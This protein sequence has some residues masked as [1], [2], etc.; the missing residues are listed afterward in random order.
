M[1]IDL[2]SLMIMQSF[3][4]ACA[5]AVMLAAWSQN[6]KI[7]ALAL[8]GIADILAA[9]GFVSLMLGLSLRQPTWSILGVTLLNFQS[10]LTW[11]AARTVD[12]KPA[13]IVV[14]FVG[15]VA[16]SLA[17]VASGIDFANATALITGTIYILAAATTFWLGRKDHLAAR[18]PLAFLTT[19]HALALAIGIYSSLNGS[20]VQNGL[21][22][23]ASLFGVIYF[24]SIVFALGTSAFLLALIKERNEAAGMTAA[25]TD[26]LTGIASRAALLESGGR[27]LERCRRKG[28]PISVM[29]F[30]LDR[31]KAVNDRHGHAV[32]DA[33]I[34]KFCE[35]VTAA[36][37]PTDLFGRMGG[38]EFAVVLPESSMEAAWVRAERI[39]ASFAE[40][41]RFV[42]HHQVNATV[43]GGVSVSVRSEQTLEELLEYSDSALYSAKAH[44]RD[45]IKRAEQPKLES[46]ITN[47]LRIA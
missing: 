40:G 2:P 17:G 44:G 41:C 16:V 38:E 39:R 25:R 31:F 4:L 13:P 19:L 37:R 30:D 3:A 15:P 27:V 28:A 14:V 36:L 47:V 18:V 23:L 32:G 34:Q 22:S 9:G 42:R 1:L 20:T 24:E 11:K 6:R 46:G 8:W 12:S 43:S 45:R 21:P 26:S 35:V 10:S 29:M 5:G 33:V 7:R